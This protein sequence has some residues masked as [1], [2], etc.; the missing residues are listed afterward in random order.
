MRFLAC[1]PD[2]SCRP[3]TPETTQAGDPV[4]DAF[5]DDRSDEHADP[6]A[7]ANQHAAADGYADDNQHANPAIVPW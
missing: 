3:G 5:A 2:T 7:D 1:P 4:A 6:D